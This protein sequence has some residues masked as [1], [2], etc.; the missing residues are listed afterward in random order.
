MTNS[1]LLAEKAIIL[2]GHGSRDAL[3]HLPIQA[4]AERIRVTS[5]STTVTCAYLELTEPSLP[6]AAASLITTGVSY[7]TIL[8]MFLGVGRH[9]REDLPA[10]I[11]ELKQNHPGTTFLVQPAVGEN[12]AVLDLLADIALSSHSI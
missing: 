7:I 4:V 10:L 9:A 3:W 1:N 12:P 6:D 5:P 2:F 8:P 11:A